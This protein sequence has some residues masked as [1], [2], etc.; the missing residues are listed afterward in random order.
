MNKMLFVDHVLLGVADT[1]LYRNEIYKDYMSLYRRFPPPPGTE[2]MVP[3]NMPLGIKNPWG[4]TES[5]FK[6]PEY[7]QVSFNDAADSFGQSIVVEIDQGKQVYICWSGGIDSTC[8]AVSVLK[9]LQDR[10]TDQV[11]IVMSD[12]SIQENPQFYAQHLQKFNRLEFSPYMFANIDIKNALVLDGEGG[13]QMFGSSLAN[14]VFSAHPDKIH[15]PWRT[16]VNFITKLLRKPWDTTQTWNTFYN[17]VVDS[18]D[19]SAPVETLQ[20]FFWWLNFNFKFDAVM[21]RTLLYYGEAVPDCDFGHF[22]Q[23]SS[24]RLFADKLMQQW[25]MS[26]D[27]N[28][29][30]QGGKN[31]K[32]PAKKYIYEFDKNEYYY[33]EKRKE[34]ST[35]MFN[36][37]YFGLDADYQRYSLDDRATRQKLREL[38]YP[39]A[40]GKIPFVEDISI[41][42][43]EL[44]ANFWKAVPNTKT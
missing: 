14:F 22:A 17:M 16:Q 38:F 41:P 25:A 18:I 24:R 36:R 40:T 39:N 1:Q 12:R 19:S 27:S 30:T 42:H 37:K 5:N 26:A 15:V 34:L 9:F 8:A 43:T 4:I 29:K 33:R 23:H 20:D 7:R 44:I 10:H 2:F 11:T 35:P 13:D 6:L 31:I 28:E 3:R 32:L 21:T